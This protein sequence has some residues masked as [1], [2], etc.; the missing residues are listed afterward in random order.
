MYSDNFLILTATSQ[1]QG[2]LNS[3][4]TSSHSPSTTPSKRFSTENSTRQLHNRKATR[5]PRSKLRHDCSESE[6][7]DFNPKGSLHNNQVCISNMGCICLWKS[8]RI[9]YKPFSH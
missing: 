5:H 4:Y 9:V 6:S 1:Q 8:D 2:R 7:Q 3:V